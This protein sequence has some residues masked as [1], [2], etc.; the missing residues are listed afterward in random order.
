M[1]SRTTRD[2]VVMF[3]S[4]FEGEKSVLTG[5]GR[6]GRGEEERGERRDQPTVFL[7]KK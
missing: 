5:I 6:R 4:G 3:L 2:G 7:E 1:E